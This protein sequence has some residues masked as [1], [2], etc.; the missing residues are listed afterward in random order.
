MAI[1]KKLGYGQVEPNRVTGIKQG[2]VIA[3]VPVDPTVVEA[4]G[5]FVENGIFLAWNPGKGLDGN[6]K[7]GQLELP[8]LDSS[9]IGIVYTEVKL[10]SQFTS[11]KDFALFTKAPDL[12]RMSQSPY[13][14]KAEAEHGTVIPR[15]IGLTVGDVITLNNLGDEAPAVG[16]VLKI[17]PATGLLSKAGTVKKIQAVVTNLTTMPDGQPAV[18]IVVTVAEA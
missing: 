7:K 13:Y 5:G 9:I 17:D 11:N 4:L 1:F 8:A 18:K 2:R 12:N 6:L 3:D 14:D 10:Y 15:I 16:D